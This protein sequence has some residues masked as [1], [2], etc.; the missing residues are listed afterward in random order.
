VLAKEALAGR[1]PQLEGGLVIGWREAPDL[2]VQIGD[3]PAP[4][5]ELER[6]GF[7]LVIFPT[8]CMG[9]AIPA[10]DARSVTARI[11]TQETISVRFMADILRG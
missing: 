11:P 9:A 1:S 4:V 8:V 2:G 10:M 6:L 5:R 3:P 7:K